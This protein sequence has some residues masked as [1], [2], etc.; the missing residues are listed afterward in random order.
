MQSFIVQT[1]HLHVASRLKRKDFTMNDIPS[2]LLGWAQ[3]LIGEWDYQFRT[4]DDSDHPG[5]TASGTE[6]VRAVGDYWLILENIG[7]S[8]DGTKSHSVTL[9]GYDPA[10]DRFSGA[11]AGTAV[12]TLFIYDGEPV[13]RGRILILETEGPAM[14]EGSET[15]RYR[16]V[17][18]VVD[19]DHRFTAAEV[20]QENGEW[21][22]FMRTEFT[23]KP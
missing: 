15:D 10:K 8:S 13:E 3:M 11:V 2:K 4:A 18:H 21:K 23:R 5:A 17:F 22:E 14:T 6:S 12:P 7:D 16:D 9:I 1:D 20:L 19:H